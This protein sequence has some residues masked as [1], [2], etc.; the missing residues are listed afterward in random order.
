MIESAY[1]SVHKRF[2]SGFLP[3]RSIKKNLAYTLS[4]RGYN[5][6]AVNV[7]NVINAKNWGHADSF[8]A[9]YPA[10]RAR[11]IL[12]RMDSKYNIPLHP[13]SKKIVK[14]DLLWPLK[15]VKFF[16]RETGLLK[17]NRQKINSSRHTLL[18]I[19]QLAMK[20][21]QPYFILGYLP[22]LHPSHLPE[23]Y[24]KNFLK[25]NIKNI[26][27][28]KFGR[29]IKPPKSY[30]P[31]EYI[32]IK[33]LEAK[34]DESISLL[35]K[36]IS[37][38]VQFLKDQNI[39]NNCILIITAD[40]GTSFG[41]G[42]LGHSDILLYEELIHIPLVIHMPNQIEGERIDSLASQ[43][44][45]APTILD[46]CKITKHLYIQG[47][48]LLPFMNDP[49]LSTTEPKFSMALQ[50]RLNEIQGGSV[51]DFKEGY[52]LIYDLNTEESELYNI[53]KDPTEKN[54]LSRNRKDIVEKLKKLILEKIDQ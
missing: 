9:L 24:K 14:E 15:V 49:S 12:E 33:N 27:Y 22:D 6:Y 13:W 8:S 29:Q 36:K 1:P 3:H 40:H 17:I 23:N 54:D 2:F 32:A 31:E 52:K 35:D 38:F 18:K 51:S 42:F 53:T 21:D 41:R 39:F 30:T 50:I 34:Y 26:Y 7:M 44:D 28:D 5:T 19:R 20:S 47:E 25:Q 45:I 4:S 43:I 37:K 16:G 48:S 11:N 10:L 46:M